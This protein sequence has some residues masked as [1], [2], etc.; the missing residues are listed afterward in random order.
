MENWYNLHNTNIDK[1]YKAENFMEHPELCKVCTLL[2][3][4]ELTLNHLGKRGKAVQFLFEL[5]MFVL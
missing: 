2:T 5:R 4:Q 3:L 1:K